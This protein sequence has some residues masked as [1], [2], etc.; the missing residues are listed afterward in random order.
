MLIIMLVA[1]VA[2]IV[3]KG[4]PDTNDTNLELKVAGLEEDLTNLEH[5]PNYEP[6]IN[7]LRQQVIELE[8]RIAE[9][10]AR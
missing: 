2:C 10:E 3:A 5:P 4:T 6:D 1:P 7:E 9:L 8:A